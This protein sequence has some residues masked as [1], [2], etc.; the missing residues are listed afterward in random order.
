MWVLDRPHDLDF[1][2]QLRGL[3]ALVQ[4]QDSQVNA[5]RSQ[6]QAGRIN[7]LVH[8]CCR[9]T[10]NRSQHRV[11]EALKANLPVGVHRAASEAQILV[12][13]WERSR[14]PAGAWDGGV[15]Y[16]SEG[17]N[18][19]GEHREVEILDPHEPCSKSKTYRTCKQFPT[20]LGFPSR[21]TFTIPLKFCFCMT[22]EAKNPEFGS[23][24]VDSYLLLK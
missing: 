19:W 14:R 10:A 22:W 6:D 16:P 18:F 13:H 21:T 1:A 23:F 9:S 2:P 12:L 24:P 8:R 17:G 3:E 11:P 7:N 4:P 20:L 5:L 15:V